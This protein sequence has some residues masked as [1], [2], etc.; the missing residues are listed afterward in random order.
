MKSTDPTVQKIIRDCAT[1]A[2][3][4]KTA[5]AFPHRPDWDT[6]KIGIMSEL[7]VEKFS[8][9]PA[10]SILLATGD[11]KLV[12]GNWW[13]DT[14]WGE[15]PLGEGENWLGRLLMWVRWL[16]VSDGGVSPLA[17]R[18]SPRQYDHLYRDRPSDPAEARPL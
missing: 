3:A 16:L 1:P 14:F 8:A 13:N 15:C 11:A 12:E 5:R 9:E 2:I 4:K 18:G 17:R 7:L 10:R 6:V